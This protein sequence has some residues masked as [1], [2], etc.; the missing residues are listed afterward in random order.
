MSVLSCTDI[1]VTYRLVPNKGIVISISLLHLTF[2]P[3]VGGLVMIEGTYIPCFNLTR[4]K[5][6]EIMSSLIINT[7]NP[8]YGHILSSWDLML[9]QQVF[10]FILIFAMSRAWERISSFIFLFT[11]LYRLCCC[12]GD[13]Q[14]IQAELNRATFS[15]PFRMLLCCI[16]CKLLRQ[17]QW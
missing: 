5:G 8:F 15:L 3:P 9:V 2:G 14:G 16:I 6:D 7:V 10:I 11:T 1:A 12:Q 4:K 13:S 17:R